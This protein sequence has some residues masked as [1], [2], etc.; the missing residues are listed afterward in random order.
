VS[1]GEGKRR[2]R[3]HSDYRKLT[4]SGRA[5]HRMGKEALNCV[6]LLRGLKKYAVSQNTDVLE[7]RRGGW[8][9]TEVKLAWGGGG[10]DLRRSPGY[11]CSRMG[12][13]RTNA[14]TT[15]RI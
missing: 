1:C 8:F 11:S 2:R 13:G 14:R 4:R 6:A 7:G 12:E 9:M 5:D 3:S 15:G 10:V